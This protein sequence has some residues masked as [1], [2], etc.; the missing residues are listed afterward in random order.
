M[1][2]AQEFVDRIRIQQVEGASTRRL[3]ATKL[4]PSI[5]VKVSAAQIFTFS[6]LC[7]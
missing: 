4:V 3:I 7:R 1:L 2:V 5:F 6:F